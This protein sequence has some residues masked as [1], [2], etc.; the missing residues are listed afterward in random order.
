MAAKG[1]GVALQ[2]VAGGPPDERLERICLHNLLASANEAIYFKDLEN[3]FILVSRG[4]ALHHVERQLR[5][6]LADGPEPSPEDFIGKSDLDLFDLPL[7]LEWVAEEQHII[8]TG[9]PMV[10]VLERDTYFHPDAWFE[11]SKSPLVDDEGTIIGT[12][13]VSRDV[14]A[15]VKAEQAV[16]LR[17]A[18]LRA[19]LDSSPDAITCY[20]P[21]FRYELVNAKALALLGRPVEDVVG[22]TDADLGR[23]DKV[24]TLLS[25]G[26]ERV[27]ATKRMCEVEYSTE[28]GGATSWWHVRMVPQLS[29]GGE[30][31][32]VIAAARDL[33]ELKVAQSVLAHQAN[34]DPLTGLANRLA[35]TDKLS[36]VLSGLQQKPGRIALLFIDV[37][38]FKVINDA[39]GHD[40]GDKLLVEV[41]DRLTRVSRRADT[42]AR[43]G[44]DEFVMLAGGLS[45]DDDVDV[46]AMRVLRSLR[47][48]F[49][50]GGERL[51][52]SASIGVVTTSDPQAKAGDLLRD[53]DIA[54]YRAKEQGRDRFAL[55]HPVLRESATERHRLGRDLRLAVENNEFF[56]VYQPIFAL[57][58]NALA[59]VEALV[60]WQHPKKGVVPPA[61]FIPLAEK[62]GLINALDGWALGEACRQLSDWDVN[63]PPRERF[64]M[65]V[66]VSARQVAASGF[67]D[68]VRATLADHNL[69]P[70]R[71][72]LEITETGMIT[73]FDRTGEALEALVEMGIRVALDDFGTGYSS[74]A[75]LHS[76]RMNTLKIDRS[77]VFQLDGAG[78][79]NAIVAGVVA[80]AHALGLEV[81]A[82]GVETA[83]QLGKVVAMGCDF[84]QGFYFARPARPE[85]IAELVSQGRPGL[86]PVSPA[87]AP[88]SA[89]C[90]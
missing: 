64:T 5:L 51:G 19:V 55:F 9:E 32:G 75:H 36:H 7:A 79:E 54:M 45:E 89:A 65:A 74:L 29:E 1:R 33:T 63:L 21:E 46:L 10:N 60:R 34:H 44:G 58:S 14:T 53:A 50:V 17:E 85:M 8:D 81:V 28:A 23:P 12:F 30:V 47:K 4:V 90:C 52:V 35:L 22:R 41:A 71:L 67:V 68:L 48:P 11:T 61:K 13:G 86:E 37:D 84:A 31:T 16:I 42:V 15:R 80:M 49:V 39:R 3:R 59:G 20:S 25:D 56:L 62:L 38:N 6:G 43:L 73:E 87:G 27:L 57:P 82:E 83:T 26:L 2:A 24:V 69:E 70:A 88:R 78:K 18:Q 76:F 40:I 77:F 72:S 66:N